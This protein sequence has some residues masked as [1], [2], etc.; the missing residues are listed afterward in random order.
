MRLPTQSDLPEVEWQLR[1]LW[2]TF[3]GSSEP[4]L[5]ICVHGLSPAALFLFLFL[6]PPHFSAIQNALVIIQASVHPR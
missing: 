3:E 2:R 4:N 5:L 1:N 6:Q